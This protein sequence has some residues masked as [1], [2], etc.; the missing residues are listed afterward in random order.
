[1]GTTPSLDN[2]WTV[3][4]LMIHHK[5]RTYE[6]N[7]DFNW[8]NQ[9][10]GAQKKLV[11]SQSA[12]YSQSTSCPRISSAVSPMTQSWFNF[13]IFAIH[14]ENCLNILGRMPQMKIW[15]A[16]DD[17]LFWLAG[18]PWDAV[19]SAV[20]KWLQRAYIHHFTASKN[21]NLCNVHACSNKK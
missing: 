21:I 17:T 9:V 7:Q 1:M 13:I 4:C 14:Y 18:T 5:A 16:L 12:I 15:H 10:N 11:S 19:K 3:Y 6:N 8:D 2:I 20:W